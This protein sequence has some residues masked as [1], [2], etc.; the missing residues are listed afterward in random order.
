[1]IKVILF[2]IHF[3]PNFYNIFSWF[4]TQKERDRERR[5]WKKLDSKEQKEC[6]M[7]FVLLLR[8]KDVPFSEAW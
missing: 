1:M 3:F 4:L 7:L 6:I 2:F 5:S 8:W